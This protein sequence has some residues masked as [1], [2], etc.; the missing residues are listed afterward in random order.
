M[1]NTWKNNKCKCDTEGFVP[2]ASLNRMVGS[3]SLFIRYFI[4]ITRKYDLSYTLTQNEYNI[5]KSRVYHKWVRNFR[6]VLRVTSTCPFIYFCSRADNVKL[7]PQV[8][9]ALLNSV[10][11]NCVPA[12]AEI[13]SKSHQ[14]NLSIFPNID[15]SK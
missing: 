13:H 1:Y 3:P 11:V 15:R 4:G 14:P 8:W 7:T 2:V 6:N 12:S 5:P 10:K 9:H